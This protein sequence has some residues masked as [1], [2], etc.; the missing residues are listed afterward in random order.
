M[1][2]LNFTFLS[3]TVSEKFLTEI[4]HIHY[5]GVTDGKIQSGK[6]MKNEY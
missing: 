4:F 6:R 1:F 2:V 3:Q 5:T